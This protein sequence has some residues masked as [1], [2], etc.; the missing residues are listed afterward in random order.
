MEN[1][2]RLSPSVKVP[3]QGP[4]VKVPL[5]GPSVKVPLQGEVIT[6]TIGT[7]HPKGPLLKLKKGEVDR[8][9]GFQ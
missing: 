4:S 1:S 7:V 8:P 2:R 6:S 5:Q 9:F 3:L